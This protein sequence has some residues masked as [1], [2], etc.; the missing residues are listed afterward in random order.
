MR[1][2]GVAPVS[3][4]LANLEW[5]IPAICGICGRTPVATT[6][7]SVLEFLR[8]SGRPEAHVDGERFL[9]PTRVAQRVGKVPLA[10]HLHNRPELPT[11]RPLALEQGDRVP[12]P[13]AVTITASPAVPAPRPRPCLIGES[14]GR[15][16]SVREDGRPSSR[17]NGTGVRAARIISLAQVWPDRPRTSDP[18]P[19]RRLALIASLHARV[20][21]R[22]AARPIRPANR[23]G[24]QYLHDAGRD[25]R[26]L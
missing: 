20:R 23:W 24:R 6:I 4:S 8:R 3:V 21:S 16:I 5:S 13:A 17:C 10:R 18:V 9:A 2:P 11:D 22:S 7:S 14:V 26:Q 12:T 19:L 1:S 15:T 25:R